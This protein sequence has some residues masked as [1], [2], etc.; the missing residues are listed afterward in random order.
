MTPNR[1]RFI[2]L[3]PLGGVALLAACSDKAP[4]PAPSPAPAAPPAPDPAPAPAAAP[5]A[6]AD[7]SAAPAGA[8]PLVDPSE[9]VAMGLGY[10]ALASQVDKAKNPKYADGQKCSNCALYT[11]QPGAPSGPCPLFAGKHV[12]AEAWCTAYAAKT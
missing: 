3:V 9:G 5:A 1:R 2:T 7:T 11:G 10:A 6:T 12:S 4:E 8:L